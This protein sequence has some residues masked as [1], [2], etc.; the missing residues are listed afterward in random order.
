[1]PDFLR[2]GILGNAKIARE[3]LAPAIHQSRRGVLSALGTRSPDS[4]AWFAEHYH[5]IRIHGNYGAVL[6]DPEVDAVY[7]PLPN[8]LHV[9][10]TRECLAAGKHVLCEK[11]IALSAEEIDGLIAARDASGRLAAEAVMVV[12][13]PQWRLARELV[14]DGAIGRLRQVDGVFTYN[15]A[16]DPGN[17]RNQPG[18][19]GGG[20]LDIGIYPAATTRFVTGFEPRS[21]AARIE[22]E[23]GVDTAARVHAAF[24]GFDLD[25]YCSMRMALRQEMVFHGEGGWIHL[26]APFNARGYGAAELRLIR[27]DRSEEIRRFT[28]VDQYQLQIEAFNSAVLD[29]EDFAMPLEFSRG[30]QAMIDAAFRSDP[31]RG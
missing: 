10:W 26:P 29:G 24:D 16:G 15:N 28:A 14:A 17:V 2:W 18:M 13:H 7:V 20:L 19:G 31:D 5:G 22:Y 21:V 23:G 11:P 12:H 25:F 30:T 9:E 3:W 8:H 27:P 6:S 1:M 4:A